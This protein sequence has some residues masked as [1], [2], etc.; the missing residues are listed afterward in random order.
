M[1]RDDFAAATLM[2]RMSYCSSTCPQRLPVTALTSSTCEHSFTGKI[3]SLAVGARGL[4][5]RETDRQNV[6]LQEHLRTR[7]LLTLTHRQDRKPCGGGGASSTC[8]QRLP[9]THSGVDPH[10][11]GSPH[12]QDRNAMCR[13]H[14]P[15]C[16]L[17]PPTGQRP[18][19]R[20]R[21]SPASPPTAS[22][23]PRHHPPH[24]LPTLVPLGTAGSALGF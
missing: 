12:S 17:R 24:P 11:C 8:Q 20:A 18:R 15:G 5:S 4:G 3:G 13:G 10:F 19:R 9:V 6:V 21:L 16:A 14:R 2:G 7:V 1:R 23:L 22:P